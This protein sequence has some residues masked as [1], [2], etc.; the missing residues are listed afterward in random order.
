MFEKVSQSQ[1]QRPPGSENIS[2]KAVISSLNLRHVNF[3]QHLP[4]QTGIAAADNGQKKRLHFPKIIWQLRSERSIMIKESTVAFLPSLGSLTPKLFAKVFTN[5]RMGIKM[6]RIAWIFS[7]KE[8]CSSQLGE[9]S[10]PLDRA[11]IS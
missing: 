11:Q 8:S 4:K 2:C 10:S 3:M 6:A 1:D 7:G 5:E 9:N